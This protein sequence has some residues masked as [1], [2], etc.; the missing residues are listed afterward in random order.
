L[1][2]VQYR[3]FYPPKGDYLDNIKNNFWLTSCG[4][5]KYNGPDDL[6]GVGVIGK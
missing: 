4:R 6:P 3:V 2:L 1:F 5:S